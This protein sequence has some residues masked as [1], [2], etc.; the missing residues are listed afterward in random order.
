MN[1]LNYQEQKKL[2]EISRYL[3]SHQVVI[4]KMDENTIPFQHATGVLVKIYGYYFIASAAHVF[5]PNDNDFLIALDDHSLTG[6][7]G[8][9]AKPS[10][11]N[12]IQ[13]YSPNLLDIGLLILSDSD[14]KKLK[15]KY[16]F[17]SLDPHQPK[18]IPSFGKSDYM[19][20]ASRSNNVYPEM[21]K[22]K[23]R[24]EN[25][26]LISTLIDPETLPQL[27]FTSDLHFLLKYNKRL[28]QLSTGNLTLASNKP[29]GMS[30]AGLWHNEYV[31]NK[32]TPR[33]IGIMSELN[34]NIERSLVG[35]NVNF[36]FQMASKLID[37]EEKSKRSQ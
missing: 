25:T 27:D 8:N 28:R 36:L 33:L 2:Q 6:I 12:S 13:K 30:G 31:H 19:I 37:S 9:F 26:F 3:S 1:P 11:S 22:K 35:V 14:V 4:F 5:I 15:N 16:S 10:V 34:L 23:V 17:Y 7:H 21:K 24:V 20:V 29:Q 18:H 32:F